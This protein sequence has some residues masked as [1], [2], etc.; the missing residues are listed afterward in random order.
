MPFETELK[1]LGLKDKEASVYLACLELGSAAVQQISR[2]AHVVRATTYV[3]LDSLAKRGLV[4]QYKE[5]K[6]TLFSAEPPRQ[7]MRLLEKQRE[8]IQ[9]KEHD[10]ERLLPALQILMKSAGDRPSVRYFSGKEGLH[11]MRQEIVMYSEPGD[12]IYNFTPSDH[13]DAVFA[14]QE[15]Q[16][17]RQRLAKRIKS[18]TIFSTRS[19]SQRNKLFSKEYLKLSERRF[20]P[21]DLFPSTSGMTIFKDRIA[22]GS[23]TGKL[24]GV[25]IESQSMADM[26]RRLFDLA[27]DKSES[28]DNE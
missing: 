6:K 16:Y 14:E 4:T 5:G 2:K 15:N 28:V 26:M 13:L 18:K 27:W 23:F 21:T 10:L 17:Y 22:I 7:L 20:V 1:K 3:V 25:I 12:V 11:A 24:G 19:L 9:D 8:V